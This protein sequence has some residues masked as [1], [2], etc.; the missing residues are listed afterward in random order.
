MT[1][2][3]VITQRAHIDTQFANTTSRRDARADNM[4]NIERMASQST[5]A[6]ML[7]GTFEGSHFSGQQQTADNENLTAAMFNF[8]N[9]STALAQQSGERY[10][11]RAGDT[12]SSIAANHGVSLPELLAANPQISNPNNI[13]VGQVVNLP[14]NA[15]GGDQITDNGPVGPIDRTDTTTDSVPASQLAISDAGLEFITGHEGLVLELYNDPAGHATIGVGH[16]VHLGP[17]DG[18]AS[19]APFTDGITRQEAM[20]LLRQD[21][22][23]AES[24]VRQLVQVPL[25]QA[26]FDALVS[27]T[28][29]VGA[30]NFGGSDLLQRLNQGEYDAVPA[31]L[32]RWTRG[33][34]QVLPGLVRRRADEGALFST[35]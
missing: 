1:T 12:L 6:D 33:G 35:P 15:T 17:I 2:Q 9:G 32:N 11:V 30:G 24:T 19:E 5:T 14:T 27:F 20:D 22:G 10:T 18:R 28:F 31:E 34:G 23:T 21:V 13:N 3:S 4:T 16:L 8:A 25:N 29:N 26:Q 7:A